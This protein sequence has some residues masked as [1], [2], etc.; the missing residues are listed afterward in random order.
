MYVRTLPCNITRDK[1][2]TKIV[3]KIFRVDSLWAVVNA[4]I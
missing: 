3:Y 2:V 1:I 4:Y